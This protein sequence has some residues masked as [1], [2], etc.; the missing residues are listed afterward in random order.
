M[1]PRAGLRQKLGGMHESQC[2]R[3]RRMLSR[4]TYV[5]AKQHGGSVNVGELSHEESHRPCRTCGIT[6]SLGETI[7]TDKHFTPA[8]LGKDWHV[9]P[10]TIRRIFQAEPGV[11]KITAGPAPGRNT[12]KRRMVQLRIPERVAIRVHARLSV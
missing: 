8:G 11:L 9:S 12:R 10:N 2:L 5:D 4:V 6:Q 3:F 1:E 7:A